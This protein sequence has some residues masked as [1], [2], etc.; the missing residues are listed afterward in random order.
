[1]ARAERGISLVEATVIL[2]VVSLLAAVIAPSIGEYVTDAQDAAARKDTQSIAAAMTRMLTDVGEAWFVRNGAR[3]GSATHHGPPAHASGA[4]VDMLVS[5]GA[6]PALSAAPRAA[7]TDWDDPLNHAAVQSLDNYLALNSPS[8]LAGNAYRSIAGMDGTGTFD[9]DA[10]A[11][12]NSEFAWR[13]AY[14][15]API[16]GDPWGN[17][18]AANVEFLARTQG[19]TG[20]GSRMDVVVISAGPDW[21]IDTVFETDGA[22]SAQDDI[23]AL[24]S[25]G[26]R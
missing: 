2:M 17:R 21:E 1:V 6:T 18:Y 26:T 15:A 9:P 10:G 20:S 3:T 12:G 8:N 19:S 11:T 13:G 16:D 25:G 14:L 7:G 23:F 5:S 22:T 24:V 4:R